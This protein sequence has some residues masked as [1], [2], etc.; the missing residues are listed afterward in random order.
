MCEAVSTK[1]E[2]DKQQQNISFFK[3]AIAFPEAVEASQVLCTFWAGLST[4]KKSACK[5]EKGARHVTMRECENLIPACDSEF[6]LLNDSAT[7]RVAHR[8]GR[9]I[10][11]GRRGTISFQTRPFGSGCNFYGCT[12]N[13]EVRRAN[14]DFK[15]QFEHR[16][17]YASTILYPF[18]ASVHL[19][20]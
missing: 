9:Y 4:A 11:C 3:N 20:S 12:G 14:S 13:W 7:Q 17:A 10:I 6:T 15:I 8:C 19:Q 5:I 18:S 2:V 1:P 16:S